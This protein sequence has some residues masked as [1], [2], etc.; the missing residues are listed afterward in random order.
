M[1]CMYTMQHQ[2]T[3]RMTDSWPSSSFAKAT[4]LDSAEM[5]KHDAHLLHGVHEASV[6]C[7]EAHKIDWQIQVI[8]VVGD[9]GVGGQ[10]LPLEPV[11]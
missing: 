1:P 10:L 4:F 9:P 2:Y 11:V 7:A 8:H 6:L 3:A 5:R